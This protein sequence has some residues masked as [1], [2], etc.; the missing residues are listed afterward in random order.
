[1]TQDNTSALSSL[2]SFATLQ[3]LLADRGQEGSTEAILT[4]EAF[5]VQLGHAIRN[6]ENELKAIDLARYDIDADAVIV[7]GKEWR[8]CL[9]DQPKTSLSASGPVTVSRTL[10]RPDAGARSAR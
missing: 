4:F 6:V 1:M 7:G 10:H 3:E 5:E 9:A 2:A 8:K